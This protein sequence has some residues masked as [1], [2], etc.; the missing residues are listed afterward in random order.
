MANNMTDEE[1]LRADFKRMENHIRLRGILQVAFDNAKIGTIF[2]KDTQESFASAMKYFEGRL[3][4][5][6]IKYSK[7]YAKVRGNGQSAR[8]A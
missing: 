8:K 5:A 2:D 4:Q 6:L 7:T 3:N 1:E